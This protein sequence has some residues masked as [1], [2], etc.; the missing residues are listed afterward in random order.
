MDAPLDGLHVK[1][2]RCSTREYVQVESDERIVNILM[3]A[4]E[5]LVL[6]R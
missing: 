2:E 4:R 1:F 5:L 3:W 6:F